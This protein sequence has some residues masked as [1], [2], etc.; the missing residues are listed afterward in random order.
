LFTDTTR[1]PARLAARPKVR[2]IAPCTTIGCASSKTRFVTDFATVKGASRVVRL[3][4]QT[5]TT[6]MSERLRH[7]PRTAPTRALVTNDDDWP[8][9]TSR[10][11]LTLRRR[12]D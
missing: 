11:F 9:R 2:T 12:S 7:A 1:A 8:N 5:A 4:S 10:A 6:S 3:V